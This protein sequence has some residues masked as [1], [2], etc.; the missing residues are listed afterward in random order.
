MIDV[1]KLLNY[2]KGIIFKNVIIHEVV[3]KIIILTFF[4]NQ[5]FILVRALIIISDKKILI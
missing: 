5:K 2:L 4:Q 1:L 3:E